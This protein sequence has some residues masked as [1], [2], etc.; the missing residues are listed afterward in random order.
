MGNAENFRP[1]FTGARYRAVGG[2]SGFIVGEQGP[3]LF[4]P[5]TPGT[6]VPADDTAAAGGGTTTLNFNIQAMDGSDVQRVLSGQTGNIIRMI[7]EQANDAGESFLEELDER[8]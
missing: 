6:I 1:A 7:R 5:D 3:E 2:S 4:M 8:Y